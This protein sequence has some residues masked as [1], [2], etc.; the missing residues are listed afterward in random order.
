MS[1]GGATGATAWRRCASAWGR[2]SP[3]SSIVDCRLQIG[4]IYNLPEPHAQRL[5]LER[6]DLEPGRVAVDLDRPDL[7]LQQVGLDGAG[8]RPPEGQAG[9]AALV[10]R[11]VQ[12]HD[13][14]V[15]ILRDL[16]RLDDDVIGRRGKK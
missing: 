12:S 13:Q 10:M 9:R 2:G 15:A 8:D 4:I 11:L 5:H 3:P 7:A 1:C 6:A 16:D 14:P